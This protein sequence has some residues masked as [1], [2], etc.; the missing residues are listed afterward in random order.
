MSLN[1]LKSAAVIVC[2]AIFGYSV[3]QFFKPEPKNRFIA[4]TQIS[5]L[6][7]ERNARSLFDIKTELTGLAAKDDG[8][9]IVKIYVEALK[10]VSAGLTYKW[11]LPA[12]AQIK[13]GAESAAFPALNAGEKREFQ[14]KV[15]GFSKQFKKFAS[16]EIDGTINQYPIHREVLISSRLEDSLEYAIQQSE[17]KKEKNT[18]NKM[19]QK[20]KTRFDPKHIVH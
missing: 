13:E 17:L 18:I 2:G 12:G 10:P 7:Q 1:F 8:V 11:N 14:I 9:S 15:T 6:G 5:K 3:I 19:G 16:F 20:S 4:S